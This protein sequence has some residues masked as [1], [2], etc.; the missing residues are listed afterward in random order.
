MGISGQ[1]KQDSQIA[2]RMMM[3]G[4]VGSTALLLAGCATVLPKGAPEAA[5]PPVVVTPPPVTTTELPQDVGRHRIALLVPTTGTNAGVGQAIANAANMAV[6]DTGGQAIR[7]TT[8]DT[9][10]G[11]A[12]A[13]Q[14]A[15]NDGNQLILGP[16]LAED[17]RAVAPAARAAHV[18]VVS[19]TN[20]TSVG[21]NGVW[22]MGFAPTQSINRIV[23]YAHEKGLDTI[24]GL[25]PSGV[26]G[27]RASTALLHAVEASGG[28]VVSMQSYDHSPAGMSSAVT[29]LKLGSPFEAVMIADSGKGATLVAPLIRKSGVTNA[30]ILGNELWNVDH[31]LGQSPGMA[32]AWYASVSDALFNQL[33]NK[34]R[35]RFGKPAP[36][37]AS[38]GYDAVL[39]ATK[40]AGEWRNGGA[41][42]LNKLTDKGGF[43]GIDGVFRFTKEGV[44]ERGLQVNQIT[45]TGIMVISPAPQSLGN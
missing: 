13:A 10:N 1:V 9:S 6:L 35:A 25:A 34:Y 39:L 12:A 26:Y 45:P 8:Y 19:F 17:V 40:I 43:T 36:R 42:P 11:A 29:K 2:R 33:N 38:L 16:L 31:G 41:F 24:A 23:A 7:V 3:R 22:A 21:G 30:R 4:L 20:D 14:K 37:L 32:G 18:P 15:L 44:A 28:K 5:P 27:Q